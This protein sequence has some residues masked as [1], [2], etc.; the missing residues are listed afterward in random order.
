MSIRKLLPRILTVLVLAGFGR[1]ASSQ[2]GI[3]GPPK[4]IVAAGLGWLRR[5]NHPDAATNSAPDRAPL[6]AFPTR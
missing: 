6:S 2:S 1:V 3:A 4:E 5:P